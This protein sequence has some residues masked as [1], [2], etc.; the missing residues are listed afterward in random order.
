MVIGF[1]LLNRQGWARIAGIIVYVLN[2]AG[3]LLAAALTLAILS[4]VPGIIAATVAVFWIAIIAFDVWAITVLSSR[5][6]Q[7]HLGT[8]ST[9]AR[10]SRRAHRIEADLAPG[11]RS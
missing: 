9:R 8:A 10:R 1:S 3:S 2:A 7:Q 4:Q 6:V 5:S 11:S